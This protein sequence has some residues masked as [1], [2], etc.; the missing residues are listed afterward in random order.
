MRLRRVSAQMPGWS[1]RGRGKGFEY[2]DENDELLTGEQRQRC[3]D[4][5]IPP[6]W[7]HVWICPV[8]NGHLQATGIDDFGRRQYLYHPVWRQ[9]REREKFD[10]TLAI[11]RHLPQAR[12]VVHHDLGGRGVSKDRALAVAFTLLDFGL[13][14]IGSPQYE[15]LHG[16]YGLSTI[17]VRQ[18]SF[19]KDGARFS[20]MGKSKITQEI[21]IDHDELV[22]ALRAF[23]RGRQ[24]SERLLHYRSGG[25]VH[26]LDANEINA[27]I[28]DF[29]GEE[30]T[31]KDFRTWH[32]TVFAA[33]GL[34]LRPESSRTKRERAVREVV[35]ETAAILGN[36]PAIAKSSYIDPRVVDEYLHGNTIELGRR[37]M[38]GGPPFSA[39]IEAAVLDFLS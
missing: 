4:L 36:T 24:S 12:R 13:F 30:A 39:E 32:A 35:K 9:Q 21:Y 8:P 16:S 29:L 6:A 14:R 28:H 3:I 18:L 23:A 7:K 25:V 31:A 10:H 37:K 34:A 1:R 5:V 19:T 15:E 2:R 38:P 17:L 11:A 20:F 33:C 22:R 27:Y 26:H